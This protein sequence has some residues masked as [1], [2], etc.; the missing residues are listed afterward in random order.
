[1]YDF[2]LRLHHRQEHSTVFWCYQSFVEER[3]NRT[4]QI[5]VVGFIFMA[6]RSIL[7]VHIRTVLEALNPGLINWH[8]ITVFV[9]STS[10]KALL[11]TGS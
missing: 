11:M 6:S 2:T 4:F 9:F 3:F 7:L 1:M 5:K 8:F 10:H